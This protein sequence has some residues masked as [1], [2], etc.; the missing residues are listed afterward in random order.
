MFGEK[1]TGFDHF[2]PNRKCLVNMDINAPLFKLFDVFNCVINSMNRQTDFYFRKRTFSGNLP[3]DYVSQKSLKPFTIEPIKKFYDPRCP[4]VANSAPPYGYL[5]EIDRCWL[6]YDKTVFFWV[7]SNPKD[8]YVCYPVDFNVEDIFIFPSSQEIS[9]NSYFFIL[10]FK[11]KSNLMFCSASLQC[12]QY[13]NF[14]DFHVNLNTTTTVET[15]YI[16]TSCKYTDDYRVFFGASNQNLYELKYSI[17]PEFSCR[18]IDVTSAKISFL[19]PSIFYN[20]LDSNPITKIDIDQ[21]IIY[22]LDSKSNIH[23]YKINGIFEK[24]TLIDTLS[25]TDLSRQ[26]CSILNNG[27]RAYISNSAILESGELVKESGSYQVVHL[28]QP[29]FDD[30]SEIKYIYSVCFTCE[31]FLMCTSYGQGYRVWCCTRSLRSNSEFFQETITIYSLDKPVLILSARRI[32]EIVSPVPNIIT[33]CFTPKNRLVIQLQNFWKLPVI[34]GH[35]DE[36]E[37][38]NI[39]NK[40]CYEILHSIYQMKNYF[41][42]PEFSTYTSLSTDLEFNCAC[43][44]LLGLI[45]DETNLIDRLKTLTFYDVIFKKLS[46][47]II[48]SFL[49]YLINKPKFF[50]YFIKK[51]SQDAALFFNEEFKEIALAN[52]KLLDALKTTYLEIRNKNLSSCLET[53]LK[54]PMHLDLGWICQILVRL[55]FHPNAISLC[56]NVSDSLSKLEP[57]SHDEDVIHHRAMKS[58][59][60]ESL[61]G[62]LNDSYFKFQNISNRNAW[63]EN[64]DHGTDFHS[65]NLRATILAALQPSRDQFLAFQVF[66]WILNNDFSEYLVKCH[67]IHVPEY[68]NDVDFG[69]LTLVGLKKARCLYEIYQSDHNFSLAALQLYKMATST[70]PLHIHEYDDQYLTLTERADYLQIAHAQISLTGV[71]AENT[72]LINGIKHKLHIINI[73]NKVTQELES[74]IYDSKTSIDEDLYRFSVRRLKSNIM[75]AKTILDTIVI[76]CQLTTSYLLLIKNLGEKYTDHNYL[77]KIWEFLF[78]QLIHLMLTK[79]FKDDQPDC[80]NQFKALLN[81]YKG[82]KHCFPIE[83]IILRFETVM[84]GTDL[85]HAWLPDLFAGLSIASYSE[86]AFHLQEHIFKL[87]GS[88]I[89]PMGRKIVVY[90]LDSYIYVCKNIL[91]NQNKSTFANNVKTFNDFLESRIS[92][93][94]SDQANIEAFKSRIITISNM[95]LGFY[96]NFTH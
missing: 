18:L 15:N 32:E 1:L 14:Y 74:V 46:D 83:N 70:I 62:V 96:Q 59:I 48:W 78:R 30:I 94:K 3:N 10:I 90:L 75:S 89:D 8:V 82:V 34:V 26:C 67:S 6:F 64:C 33:Q 20:M 53:Y 51:F 57:L 43:L 63:D 86:Y 36:I 24:L 11:S 35:L 92:G 91:K 44:T 45:S 2:I 21:N 52:H 73:Q 77:T 85:G 42:S 22:A 79:H 19:I 28:R 76:P 93:L 58:K 39:S 72:S 12:D 61:F 65:K 88:Q 56:L 49:H 55:N 4:T 84:S 16:L 71:N 9:N 7:S 13:N 27:F 17:H 40:K 87:I 29:P 25:F 50:E 95:I 41:D 68:L 60:I 81:E 38:I 31:Y 69:E 23:V 47:E 37:M 5:A 66:D 80:L 54:Y